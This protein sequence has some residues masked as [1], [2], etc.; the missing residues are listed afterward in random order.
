MIHPT[1]QEVE[2]IN[3]WQ[4]FL[5]NAAWAAIIGL[6]RLAVPAVFRRLRSPGSR[7]I[8]EHTTAHG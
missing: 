7:L 8:G 2:R 3:S 1:R 4:L 5:R 6:L